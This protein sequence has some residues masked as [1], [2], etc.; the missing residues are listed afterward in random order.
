MFTAERILG[1]AKSAAKKRHADNPAIARKIVSEIEYIQWSPGYAEPGY[2][3]PANGA[4]VYRANWN[5]LSEWDG[6]ERKSI[7]DT[8]PRLSAILEHIGAGI[9][10][11]D[12][13]SDCYQCGKLVRTSPDSYGWQPSYIRTEDGEVCHECV[14]KD[15]EAYLLELEG[16]ADRAWTL[17]IDPADHGYTLLE[18]G[19]EN[20]FHPGQNDDP[21]EIAG[22]LRARGIDN[23][24]FRLDS[25]GQFDASFS[26]YVPDDYADS[27]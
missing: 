15:P 18:E 10:W 12:E 14:S 25:V 27:E 11:G 2:Q 23:F 16:D 13:W 8:M 22:R 17:D 20:G 1:S 6:R 26:V 4:G 3:T 24:V 19:F 21:R 5:G 9:E 7:D